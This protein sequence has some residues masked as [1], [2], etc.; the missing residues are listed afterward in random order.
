MTIDY[1]GRARALVGTRFRAQGRD[2]NGLDCVGVIVATFGIDADEVRRDYKLSSDHRQEVTETLGR[3][4]R[5]VPR[6]WLRP[7][8]LLLMSVGDRQTHLAVRTDAG[9]VHAHAGI[10]RVVET[11]S[12]PEWPVLGIYRRR[13]RKR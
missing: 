1:A 9:F 5:K 12:M 2:A 7:G 13:S 6:A 11:P 10:R 4:F 3:H 8:D